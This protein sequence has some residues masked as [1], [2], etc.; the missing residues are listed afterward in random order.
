MLTRSAHDPQSRQYAYISACCTTLFTKRH[1]FYCSSRYQD[2]T[3]CVPVQGCRPVAYEQ[4]TLQCFSRR[5]G[6]LAP[7]SAGRVHAAIPQPC[8]GVPTDAGMPCDGS[9]SSTRPLVFRPDGQ[10]CS[11]SEYEKAYWILLET[12]EDVRCGFPYTGITVQEPV[13]DGNQ[14]SLKRW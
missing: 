12:E 5:P 14:S 13:R 3:L 2:I 11:E 1:H 7:G 4:T 10:P 6:I 9:S 8:L